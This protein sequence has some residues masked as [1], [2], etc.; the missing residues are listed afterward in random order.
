M[1]FSEMSL[2]EQFIEVACFAGL[3]ASIGMAVHAN[4]QAP[5]NENLKQAGLTETKINSGET[6]NNAEL[7][8]LVDVNNRKYSGL[9][10]LFV[11]ST[12]VLG[13]ASRRR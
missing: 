4:A 12:I 3:A 13:I 7:R 8:N 11:A 10:F 1:S 2:K 6:P 5:S 9:C